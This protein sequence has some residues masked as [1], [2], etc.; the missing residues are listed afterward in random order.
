M[1]WVLVSLLTVILVEMFIRL[2]LIRTAVGVADIGR[3]ATR[4]LMAKNVSDHWKERASRAY[5]GRMMRGSFVL[6][7]GLGLIALVGTALTLG[8]ERIAPGLAEA[9]LSWVG[10]LVSLV[11]ATVYVVVRQKIVRR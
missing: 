4:A 10:L 11:V 8:G 7:G 1:T 6:A 5:A 9:L 3:R 2:P